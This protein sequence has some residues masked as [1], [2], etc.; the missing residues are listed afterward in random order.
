VVEHTGNPEADWRTLMRPALLADVAW[1]FLAGLRL[2]ASPPED[3]SKRALLDLRLAEL[4]RRFLPDQALEQLQRAEQTD[5]AE[6]P[7]DGPLA[8]TT[9]R[10]QAFY[11]PVLE[12]P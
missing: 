10:A 5:G 11:A 9:I 6:L 12:R 8:A 4:S 7:T 3:P 2:R 1:Q